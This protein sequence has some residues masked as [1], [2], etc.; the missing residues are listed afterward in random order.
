MP[1]S[2]IKEMDNLTE[3]LGYEIEKR[4]QIGD[5]VRYVANMDRIGKIIG[6]EQYEGQNL[7]KVNWHGELR[8]GVGY[9]SRELCFLPESN[10]NDSLE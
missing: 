8:K 3:A 1:E 4:P 9:L 7:Y 2:F 5:N 10:E 6:I